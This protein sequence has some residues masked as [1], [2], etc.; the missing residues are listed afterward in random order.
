VS[1]C[2]SADKAT[3]ATRAVVDGCVAA[4]YGVEF[5]GQASGTRH[6]LDGCSGRMLVLR[7]RRAVAQCGNR[8]GIVVVLLCECWYLVAAPADAMVLAAL[9]AE[10]AIIKEAPLLTHATVR[11]V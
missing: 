2:W 6:G 4:N 1:P 8:P 9:R 10:F 7:R 11:S 3:N 5:V